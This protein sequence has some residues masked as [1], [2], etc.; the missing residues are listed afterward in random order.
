MATQLIRGMGSF[1]KNCDCT[2]QS[3]CP[4]LYTIRYR[5]ATGRQREEMGYATQQ[6]ALDRLT[7]LYE[8]KR[9]TPRQ[10]AD[11]KRKIGRQRFGASAS[12]WTARQRHY[13]PGSVR[14]VTQTLG[15]FQPGCQLR[16]PCPAEC[17]QHGGRLW[18]YRSQ[19]CHQLAW[20]LTGTP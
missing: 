3:R 7:R 15:L 1:F 14:T 12:D 20:S 6:S 2:R 8:E 13:A 18:I 5:D 16:W 17:S 9:N 11:L 10:Q 4:N 19:T